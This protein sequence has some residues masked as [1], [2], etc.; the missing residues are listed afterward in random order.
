MRDELSDLTLALIL[1]GMDPSTSEELQT[2]IRQACDSLALAMTLSHEFAAC[3][4]IVAIAKSLTPPNQ[5]LLISFVP[6][7]SPATVRM[8]RCVARA[9]LLDATPSAV[10]Y[11]EEL[12][13]LRPLIELLSPSHG[14]GRYFDILANA[15]KEG[16]F[17][18]LVSRVT[19][20]SKA[21]TDIDEYTIVEKRS[22]QDSKKTDDEWK[23]EEDDEPDNEKDAPKMTALEQIKRALEVLHG[24]IGASFGCLC[25]RQV[26]LYSDCSLLQLTPVL[27]T[28]TVLVPKLLCSGWHY[29][30]TTSASRR[31]SRQS[32]LRGRA[33]YSLTSMAVPL[34]I[35]VDRLR[36]ARF[37]C[38][39]AWNPWIELLWLLHS[40]S[41]V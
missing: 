1:I 13:A 20:V 16:Y 33:T 28:S 35:R 17:D 14:S 6:C 26:G 32:V 7:I 31:S 10:E 37:S 34:R 23:G 4:R 2:D 40:T 21:L 12:P 9:L 19:L 29:A 41:T 15:E 11:Q 38:P 24:R 22:M 25:R 3:T 5:A 30:S 27:H 39:S 18:D 8:S 36:H